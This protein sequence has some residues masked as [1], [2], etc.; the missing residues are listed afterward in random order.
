MPP[1]ALTSAASSSSVA[2]ENSFPRC[3]CYYPESGGCHRYAVVNQQYCVYCLD[4]ET[5]WACRCECVGCPTSRRLRR[6][7]WVC[8]GMAS[9]GVD[10]SAP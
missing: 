2:A 4:E 3:M 7:S 1:L 5:N 9:A 10:L 8:Y 6:R